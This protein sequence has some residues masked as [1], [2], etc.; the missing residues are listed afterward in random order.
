[1]IAG[2]FVE[3]GVEELIIIPV[4]DSLAPK[5]FVLDKS[6]E[7]TSLAGLAVGAVDIAGVAGLNS[8]KFWP[9]EVVLNFEHHT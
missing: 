2:L 3:S 6:A 4:L 1:V 7:R 8:T 5:A 9:T